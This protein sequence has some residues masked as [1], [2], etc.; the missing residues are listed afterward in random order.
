ML[1]S[2]QLCLKLHRSQIVQAINAGTTVV[3]DRY[4]YSGAVYSAAKQLPDLDLRWARKPDEGL[5]RPDV[6]LFLELSTEE[7]A[8]RGGF[9]EERYEKREVQQRVREL[10]GAMKASPDGEDMITIDAGGSIEEVEK[11]IWTAVEKVCRDVDERGE[12]LRK[13]APW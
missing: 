13:L 2:L 6:C 1:F 3:V 7:A 10:F 11:I 4:I 5:P 9:G 8:K 12:P